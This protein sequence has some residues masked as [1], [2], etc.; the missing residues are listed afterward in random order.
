MRNF[1]DDLTDIFDAAVDYADPERLVRERVM[2]DGTCLI[3]DASYV[4]EPKKIYMFAFG[5]A[6][7]GMAR[8]FMSVCPVDRGVVASNSID[9][10][11][12]NIEVVR[13]S[14]PL[15]DEGSVKAAEKM[16]RLARQADEDTL[17]VFLVSGGG[18]AI[19]ASPAFGITLEEKIQTTELLIKSGASIDEINTVRKH[20]SRVKGGRLAEAAYPAKCVTLAVSDVLSG[21]PGTVASGPTYY[22]STSWIDAE[23]VIKRYGLEPELPESVMRALGRGAKGKLAETVKGWAELYT[24]YMIGSNYYG[25]E[26]AREKA[27]ELGYRVR[28]CGMLRGDVSE[29]SEAMT[30]AV[31]EN[32]YGDGDK[33]VC[34]IFGGEVTV[35]VTGSGKGGRCQQLAIEYLIREKQCETF[36]LCA[37][38]DGMDGP[39]DAAGAFADDSLDRADAEMYAFTN[40]A[41]SFFEKNGSLLK[42]GLTGTNINDLYMVIIPHYEIKA[43]QRAAAEMQSYI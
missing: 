19:L 29:S 22:D 2:L 6:A 32:M 42:T 43:G 14:H 4:C 24:Y 23:A 33:P 38:T 26:A 13:A 15:P 12:E 20:I 5:K 39:T 10:F 25:V 11:P 16:L 9:V 28:N 27:E 18:S 21:A 36:A 41:Y 35:N 7:C 8:G 30:L 40:D 17:C 3:V 1:R 34:L 31:A 37:S